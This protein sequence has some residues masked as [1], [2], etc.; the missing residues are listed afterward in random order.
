MQRR[1]KLLDM[2]A[3]SPD[4]A[5]SDLVVG[6]V[7]AHAASHIPR[8]ERRFGFQIVFL[9]SCRDFDRAQTR[10]LDVLPLRSAA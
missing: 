2:F 7:I 4:I 6:R 3:T 1:Q 9:V 8:V 10:H 5:R